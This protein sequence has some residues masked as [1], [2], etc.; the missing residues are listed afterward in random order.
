MPEGVPHTTN[1]HDQA[2]G[3]PWT[4]RAEARPSRGTCFCMSIASLRIHLG[5][6]S[7]AW[8]VVIIRMHPEEGNL[9]ESAERHPR[10]V[11][12]DAH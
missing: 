1:A 9:F 10:P 6:S 8:L 3:E 5:T 12:I 11:N 2:D 7:D 4:G